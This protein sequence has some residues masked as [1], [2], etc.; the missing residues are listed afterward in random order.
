M[1]EKNQLKNIIR[2]KLKETQ[3]CKF[4]NAWIP[5]GWACVYIDIFVDELAELIEKNYKLLK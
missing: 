4:K 3:K 2:S 5:K 1:K